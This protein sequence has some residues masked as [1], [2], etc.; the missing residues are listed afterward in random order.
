MKKVAILGGAFDPIHKGH[1]T[2]TYYID[3]LQLADEIWIVPCYKHMY[4]K[5]MTS[6]E[7]RLTMCNLAIEYMKYSVDTPVKISDFEIKNKLVGKSYDILNKI[8]SSHEDIQIS[9]VIGQDNAD[10]IE[11][12]YEPQ[13]IINEF[14]FIVFPRKHMFKTSNKWYLKQPHIFVNQKLPNISSTEI[15]ENINTCFYKYA[16]LLSP[17]VYDYIVEKKLYGVT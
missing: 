17:K 5:N 11:S 10:M 14:P 8:K 15:R 3:M 2:M 9:L 12:W 6:A 1:I 4:G 13:K 7:D 16:T